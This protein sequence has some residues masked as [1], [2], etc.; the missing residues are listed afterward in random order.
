MRK[1]YLSALLFGALL[2]A[3][4]GTFTSCKDYDD[5]IS[6]L[7]SQIDGLATKDDM[8][9]KLDQMQT[10]VNDA[11]AT[12]EEALE[13]ANAAGD[14]DKIA[15]LE[16]RIADLEKTLGDIDAMKEEIQNALDSQ[17][18]EFRAEMEE[19]LAQVE[20]LTG[21]SLGMVTEIS[22]QVKDDDA[23]AQYDP[24]LDVNYA[25][26]DV[27][28]L[29][30]GKTATSYTFGEGL[31]GA[32]SLA[33]GDVNTVTDYML[34]NVN[35]ANAVISNDMLSLVNGNGVNLN[36][37]VNITS[38]QWSGDIIASRATQNTG[39]RLVGVQ[40]KEDVD[41]ESFDKLVLSSSD[42]GHASDPTWCDGKDHDYIAYALAVTDAEKGRSVTSAYDVTLHVQAEQRAEDIEKKS[43]IQ[44]DAAAAALNKA[45]EAWKDGGDAASGY[46]RC[47]PVEAGAPFTINVAS[48]LSKGGRVMA[49]YVTVDYNNSTLST[50]DKAAL[51]TLTFSGVDTVIKGEELTHSI[52]VNGEAGIPVPLKLVTI[53]YRGFIEENTIWVKAGEAATVTAAYTVTPTSYVN[54]PAAY[55][56]NTG[57]KQAFTIPANAHFYHVDLVAGETAHA[58]GVHAPSV[59]KSSGYGILSSNWSELNVNGND[60][61]KLYKADKNT[62]AGNQK[63]VAYAEFVG[64]LNLQM[65]REDKTY[66]G[67]IKFYD[68]SGTYLG[69][70]TIQVTKKL[71]TAVPADFSAKTNGIVNGVMTV[72]P[73]PKGTPATGEYLLKQA[74]NNWDADYILSIDGITNSSKGVYNPGVNKGDASTASILNINTGVINDGKTY[75]A[76]VEY[77]YGQIAFIPE[78]HGV[79]D[80]AYDYKVEWA[81]DFS[82]K[83]GCWPVDCTYQWSET[84]VVYYRE[85]NIIKGKVT[86]A[87]NGTVTA[88]EN[89]IKAI[90]PYKGAVD[91][92]DA[93]DT[94]WT[95]WANIL[96][97]ASTTEIILITNNNGKEI[98]NEYFT[99]KFVAATEG[100]ITKT[101]MELTPTGAQVQVGEDIETKVILKIKDKFG[102]VEEIPALTFTMKINHE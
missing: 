20:E 69:T 8:Q 101:A 88:F 59:F 42:A 39:L 24:N 36:E 17:I 28:T 60:F 16:G 97:N 66:T 85:T 14:A 73:E 93:T 48:D 23:P 67:A 40:L 46:E 77:N 1:K 53:D 70:N 9:A 68:E 91:P 75:A 15:E 47:F 79:I 2:F 57:E 31:T 63:E 32:F 25:R 82:I 72:Y 64:T 80:D 33:K 49:S 27:I 50:T 94:D 4:A 3:S 61:L 45:I 18:A 90:S 52:T 41:F 12:A 98:E 100:S 21:Y 83:F 44:S 71:P 26:I 78:G 86:K 58:D 19:L 76:T 92:F 43:T 89:V 34:V 102:H 13:K 5:D 11:K 55:V 99:A 96:S 35:P 30:N 54:A 74:F 56:V 65:M 6:N 87:A 81:T 51:K 38:A 29:P 10:A 7:Q 37:Y 22:F 84:P 95:T 62:L